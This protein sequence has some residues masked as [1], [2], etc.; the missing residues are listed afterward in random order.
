MDGDAKAAIVIALHHG[1]YYAQ[2]S[3]PYALSSENMKSDEYGTIGCG[4]NID[5]SSDIVSA[6]ASSVFLFF[7]PLRSV[8]RVLCGI[9]S[10][11]RLASQRLVHQ[12][13]AAMHE[14]NNE[15]NTDNA[16]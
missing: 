13:E 12:V 5:E 7:P 9:M 3:T 15:N 8:M 10:Q 6:G 16:A 1:H 2:Q 11:K 14:N 4:P